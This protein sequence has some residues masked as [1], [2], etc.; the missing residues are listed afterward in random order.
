MF[1]ILNEVKEYI[2]MNGIPFNDIAISY[3]YFPNY[4]NQ[5]ILNH[6]RM[7]TGNNNEFGPSEYKLSFDKNGS[8]YLMVHDNTGKTNLCIANTMLNLG[9]NIRY[10]LVPEVD[11]IEEACVLKYLDE[12]RLMIRDMINTNY[13]Q[14]DTLS[15]VKLENNIINTLVKSKFKELS[16]DNI[17][18]LDKV[19]YKKDIDTSIDKITW[20]INYL[21]DYYMEDLRLAEAESQMHGILYT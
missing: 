10:T 11:I 9:E 20:Y 12:Q 17:N 13:D 4:F 1:S 8:M 15:K 2:Q 16:K 7:L 6:L 5:A 14:L 21:N 18:I 19:D 3:S